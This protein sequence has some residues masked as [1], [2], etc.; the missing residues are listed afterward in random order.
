MTGPPSS[1][2]LR[3]VGA[4]IGSVTATALAVLTLPLV[5]P[6]I[7]AAFGIPTGAIVGAAFAPRLAVAH[8]RYG[9]TVLHAAAVAFALGSTLAAAWFAMSEGTGADASDLIEYA[10]TIGFWLAVS[11]TTFSA[12]MALLVAIVAARALRT[13]APYSAAL[14]VPSV[15]IV[16]VVVG[17]SG[18]AVAHAAGAAGDAAAQIGDRIPFEYV[19]INDAP[20]ARATLEI[21]SYWKGELAGGSGSHGFRCG[22]GQDEIQT[23]WAIWVVPAD[24]TRHDPPPEDPL[25]SAAEYGHGQ[26]VR[27][28]I[29]VGPDGV[30]TWERGIQE[31]VCGG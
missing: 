21:R 23:D 13:L 7:I 24:D 29:R 9:W 4:A 26:P 6:A 19:A 5:F 15:V 28:T 8:D 22:S 10:A 20:D 16:A 12:P 31:D 3:V 30:A 11:T 1:W 18:A 25:V 27:V 17:G 2:K 14:W